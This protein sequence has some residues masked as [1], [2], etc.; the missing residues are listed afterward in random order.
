MFLR[1]LALQKSSRIVYAS[2]TGMEF[3]YSTKG[4]TY[5]W[6][7]RKVRSNQWVQIPLTQRLAT[8]VK[9]NDAFKEV[10]N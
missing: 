10:T 9:V 1:A 4:E 3:K 5:M 6:A 8:G 2:H 7:P